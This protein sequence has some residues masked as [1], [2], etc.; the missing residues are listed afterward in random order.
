MDRAQRQEL[1]HDKFVEQVGQSVEYAAAHTRQLARYGVVAFATLLIGAGIYWFLRSAA[2]HRQE[3]LT[4]A[5]RVQE[6]NVGPGTSDFVLSYPT[7]QDKDKASTK[8][9]TDLANKYPGKR[10]GTI[11]QYYLGI[12]AADKGNMSEAEKYLKAAVDSGQ[13]DYASQAKFSLA[14]IY[15]ATGRTAEA[16]KLLRSLIDDPS[17]L[18]SKEQATIAL[19]RVLSASKPAEARKL[20]EPLRTSRGAVSRAAITALGELPAR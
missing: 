19:A 18:V 16:E 20:L 7:Q 15:S 1:K 17:F 9:F 3:D 12:S 6:A 10:E 13:K 2:A 11:A 4:A 14:D 5:M 8:A